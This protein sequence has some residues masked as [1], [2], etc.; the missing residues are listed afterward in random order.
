VG[1]KVAEK[2][3]IDSRKT[4]HS[5]SLLS[6]RDFV[7]SISLNVRWNRHASKK[8]LSASASAYMSMSVGS[9]KAGFAVRTYLRMRNVA[10]GVREIACRIL[11]A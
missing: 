8:L 2:E 9:V 4:H 11:D 1:K 6:N 5:M 7:V 3:N 10:S